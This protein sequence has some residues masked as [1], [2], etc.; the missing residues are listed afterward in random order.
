MIFRRLSRIR[1]AAHSPV[2][3]RLRG[4]LIPIFAM[5]SV[6]A[7][8]AGETP[9]EPSP[10]L[11]QIRE[12]FAAWDTDANGVLVA[13]EIDRALSQPE[14]RGDAAAALVALKRGLKASPGPFTIETLAT[15][16][17]DTGGGAASHESLTKLFVWAQERIA[18]AR[19]ELFFSQPP[20][21]EALRQGKLG[22]CFCLAALRAMIERE[23]AVLT[24]MIEPRADGTYLVELGAKNVAVPPLTDGEIALGASADDGLWPLVYEK[25]VG[26][27]RMK[28]DA[29]E[30]TPLNTV[31][32]GG[33]AGSMMGA[34]TQH[35]IE[36][37]SCKTWREAGAARGAALLEE[38]RARL[39]SAQTE[40]R[41]I[42][43]GT[44]PLPR[45]RPAVPGIIFNHGY[46]VLRY[47]EAGDAVRLWNPHGDSFRPKG[48]AGLVHGYPMEHGEF[49]VP[50]SELVQFF[51]GFA[52]EQRTPA[53]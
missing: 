17:G 41:L 2:V 1:A 10:F 23:P 18:K 39:R 35:A 30:A 21:A 14:F 32:K 40:R 13:A 49:T 28:E 45:D 29:P 52:F 9:G 16:L 4:G 20:R 43:G 26:L 8:V 42:T 33:S 53:S 31:T 50:L 34:L 37:W 25:A 15:R 36:R 24:R 46:T 51:G 7:A 3:A 44:G 48:P 5:L 19:R 38:L 12:H 27:A 11:A 22:D 6:S 47:D